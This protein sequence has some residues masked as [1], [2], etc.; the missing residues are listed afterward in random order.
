VRLDLAR[1]YLMAPELLKVWDQTQYVL[2]RSPNHPRALSYAAVVRLA[3]GQ[4]A[5]ALE[6]LENALAN[7]PTLLDARIHLSLAYLQL[8]RRAEAIRVLNEA[9]DI[10]PDQAQMIDQILAEISQQW[11]EG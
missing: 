4:T 3:M 5:V 6:M 7:D 9:R 8:D 10:H 11:P 2:E 1:V